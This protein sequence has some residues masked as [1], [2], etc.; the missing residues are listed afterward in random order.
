MASLRS[1]SSLRGRGNASASE[2]PSARLLNRDFAVTGSEVLRSI[3]RSSSGA[4]PADVH[5]IAEIRQPAA[6]DRS[7]T[8]GS[9]MMP[10][11]P[12]SEEISI[13]DGQTSVTVEMTNCWVVAIASIG[14]WRRGSIQV[15]EQDGESVP[16]ASR[17]SSFTIA[18][19]S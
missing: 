13:Q 18:C 8:A 4:C 2:D 3:R 1:S 9:S 14:T 17:K 10:A 11:R 19:S 15:L 12:N 16:V 5:F 6:K 7:S